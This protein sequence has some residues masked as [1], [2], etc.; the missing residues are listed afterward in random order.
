[1]V[2]SSDFEVGDVLYITIA[3]MNE[4]TYDLRAYYANEFELE[5]GER[6][7]FRWGGHSTNIL[8]YKVPDVTEVG[9]TQKFEISMHPEVDYKYIEAYLSHDNKFNVIEDRPA[10]HVTD[11][12]LSVLMTS[13]DTLWCVD[14]Y[15]YIILSM[16]DDRRI[17]VTAEARSGNPSISP[18]LDSHFLV[19]EGQF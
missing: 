12:G 1:M 14:C 19:N 15:V 11:K 18:G 10:R 17:Y 13:S 9:A 2:H 3:C 6:M 8:K 4:C 7:V 5:E 16:V